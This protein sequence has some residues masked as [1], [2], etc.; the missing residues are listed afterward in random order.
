[1]LI[2]DPQ[3]NKPGG[4]SH[5]QAIAVLTVIAMLVLALWLS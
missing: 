5:W 1:M 4:Q 3:S 2:P